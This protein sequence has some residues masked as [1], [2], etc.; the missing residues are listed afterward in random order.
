METPF[1]LL[2]Y[3]IVTVAIIAMAY[4]IMLPLLF[5]AA[6]N[7]AMIEKTLK[8]S[9]TG[10]GTGFASEITTDTGEGFLGETFDTRTR[11]ATFQCNSATLC[12][13]QKKECDLAIEWDNRKV[14]FNK[15]R[16]FLVTTRCEKEYDLHTCTI[17]L[18]EP[19]A[20]IKIESF[21]APKIID[22]STDKMYFDI[23]F[24]NT[25]NQETQQT[26][27]KIKVFKKYLEEGRM[28]E[29]ELE[30]AGKTENTG[31]LKPGESIQKRVYINLNQNGSFKAIIKPAGLEAGYEEK[32]IQFET[33]GANDE[34]QAA[35]CIMPKYSEGACRS[36][37]Y[38]ENCMLGSKCAELLLDSDNIDLGLP[39]YVN[40]ENAE[41]NVLAS[42]IV[43]MK[44]EDDMCP[45]DIILE[46]PNAVANELG[47]EVKNVSMN[48]IKN[49]FMINAYIGHGTGS[50]QKIGSVEVMPEEM[51]DDSKVVK[52]ISASLAPGTHQITIT[53][54]ENKKEK[55]ENYENN[56]LSL[57]VIIPNPVTETNLFENPTNIGPCCDKQF[58]L[59]EGFV[60]NDGSLAIT[61]RDAIKQGNI[62]ADFKGNHFAVN[63]RIQNLT[64]DKIRIMLPLGQIFIDRDGRFQNLGKTFDDH[65]IEIPMCGVWIGRIENAC[66][67]RHKILP[68][69]NSYN[70]GEVIEE[71]VVLDALKSGNQSIAWDAIE[72]F[73]TSPSTYGSYGNVLIPAPT[74]LINP[75]NFTQQECED[76]GIT[77]IPQCIEW[78]PIPEYDYDLY[79]TISDPNDVIIPIYCIQP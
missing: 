2:V 63:T 24:S 75:L 45:R 44:I 14:S 27:I 6:N 71:S 16:T 70:V 53:A 32:T 77:I 15:S 73:S 79:P 62:R 34:C 46:K 10:L 64:K 42:N 59:V 22:L 13:P 50:Q 69:L 38:C 68:S 11:N 35:Y 52:S 54:N 21:Q 55:E 39:H 40:I 56:S 7:I 36:R 12:C 17:Y 48:P 4:Q 37:C 47:F 23:E 49:S 25:G 3:A 26:E 41:P 51:N 18:G 29:K 5:P 74:D 31:P 65:F 58:E 72:R 33:T 76:A 66:L 67:N 1:K 43:E 30:S 9:E 78:D 20:Q 57:S 8:A 19:P 61:I 28:Q 60:T